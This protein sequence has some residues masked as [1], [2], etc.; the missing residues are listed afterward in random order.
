VSSDGQWVG[1]RR[2]VLTDD[3][4]G[5]VPGERRRARHEELNRSLV[6]DA[7]EEAFGEHGYPGASVRDIARRSGFSSAALYLF[8]ANKEALY[9]EVLVRRGTELHDAMRSAAEGPGSPLERLHRM[10]D[11]ALELYRVRP[12]FAQLVA[13][14][15]AT[16]LGSPLA[17]WQLHADERVRATFRRAMDDEARVV[18]E[19]QALGEI[20]P[21]E[22]HALAHL[23]SVLVN[24]Y[25]AV[26]AED[27][28][29]GLT[30]D[31]LHAV[32]D[33]ALRAP[34]RRRPRAR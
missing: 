28:G 3:T 2:R 20:R 30:V 21:G 11:V 23:F 26:G 34:G 15:H 27:E 7:A 1:Y 24:S 10:A 8:F 5:G 6:L 14:A 33:G 16:M 19:G 29:D 4:A 32:I 31:Q 18:R 9:G 12:H 22:P 13:Q 17:E 25:L